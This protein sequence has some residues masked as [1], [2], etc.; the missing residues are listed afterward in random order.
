MYIRSRIYNHGDDAGL[1]RRFSPVFLREERK[2]LRSKRD[3]HRREA[4]LYVTS[5]Q[6][7][8]PPSAVPPIPLFPQNT[9]VLARHPHLTEVMPGVVTRVWDPA[10]NTMGI[11]FDGLQGPDAVHLIANSLILAGI[12]FS[13]LYF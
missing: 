13:S 11:R 6:T 9:K 8:R 12:C 2:K 1:P 10:T 7:G 5:L 4:F 3:T